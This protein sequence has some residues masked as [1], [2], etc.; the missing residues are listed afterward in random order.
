VESKSVARRTLFGVI[1]P[2]T[3]MAPIS[4]RGHFSRCL[5]ITHFPVIKNIGPL[6][7]FLHQLRRTLTS[8]SDPGL[9]ARISGD[10]PKKG[11]PLRHG[12]CLAG[13][14]L[15][16]MIVAQI[17]IKSGVAKLFVRIYRSKVLHNLKVVMTYD[18]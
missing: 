13:V 5:S 1:S 15:S 16:L 18:L 14:R 7:S 2:D 8:S 12:E 17:R 3:F 10:A 4:D 6:G 9:L 11:G